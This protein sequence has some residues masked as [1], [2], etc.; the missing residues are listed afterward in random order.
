MKKVLHFIDTLYQGGAETL[1]KDYALLMDKKKFSV[2]ILC[3]RKIGS[4]YEKILQ[5]NGIEVLFLHDY[6]PFSEMSFIHRAV[7]KILRIFYLDHL[8]VRLIVKKINPD[9]IHGHLFILHYMRWLDYSRVKNVFYTCHSEPSKYWHCKTT[10]S[11]REFV[12]AQ[13]LAKNRSMRFIA[14]H[15][16]MKMEL[17]TLFGVKNTVVLNNGI[18]F[19]KFECPLPSKIVRKRIGVPEDAFVVGH[20][21][22]FAEVKNHRFLLE[23]F[24]KLLV[25]RKDSFLLLVGEGCLRETLISK[26]KELHIDTKV[27][28]LGNRTDVPDL[29]NSM[30]VFAF[31]SIYEGLGI[32]L[33]E[34]QKMG[35][36][37]V[38]SDR[39]PSAAT[40]SNLVTTLSLE[41]PIEMWADALCKPSPQNIDYYDLEKWDI[42]NVIRKL[43]KQYSN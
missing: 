38:A 7:F 22:R 12:A 29:M 36:P 16:S 20:V 27:K 42:N 26:I 5:E 21:G 31:P 41:Q 2:T 13:W 19:A 32:V 6:L 1:V 23:V 11:N 34:A 4:E 3:L 43:E 35:L 18:N 15:N 39:V 30:N 14:L 17:N 24:S 28:I 10:F 37:C 9:I 8:L 40:I 33:I 25:K